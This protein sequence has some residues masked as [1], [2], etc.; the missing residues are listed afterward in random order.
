MS[1]FLTG[2]DLEDAITSIIWDAKE[3][4]LIMCPFIK[5]DDYFIKL[6]NNHENNDKL[7]IIIVFGKNQ[8]DISKSLSL[9]DY[10]FFKKFKNITIVYVPNLHAK[11][12]GNEKKGMITSINMYDHSFKNN[13]E[14]GVYSEAS[15]LNLGL[16]KTTDMEAWET[17][18]DIIEKNEVIFAKRPVYQKNF[19][20]SITG[21]K[22]IE[23]RVLYDVTDNIYSSKREVKLYDDFPLEID[24]NSKENKKPSR[25]EVEKESLK[26]VEKPEAFCIRC[27]VSIFR[28]PYYPYCSNCY[29]AWNRYSKDEYQLE[30]YCH[31]C[32]NQH[33]SKKAQ[34]ACYNCYNRNKNLFVDFN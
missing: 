3:V 18:W 17:C 10:N 14:F 8:Q 28:N 23:S 7:R 22:Y 32:G 20:S 11:Y 13:I 16:N 21:K 27:S 1:K 34:P 12:Y 29:K 6:F 33:N 24:L 19:L 31:I 4:L 2:S 9:T 30:R 26:L 5:L 15:F 25:L